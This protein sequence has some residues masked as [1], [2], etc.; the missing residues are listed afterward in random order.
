[1][2]A[3]LMGGNKDWAHQEIASRNLQ[4]AIAGAYA[5]SVRRSDTHS[6]EG[7]LDEFRR[8]VRSVQDKAMKRTVLLICIAVVDVSLAKALEVAK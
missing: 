3:L 5:S 1:M 8:S 2:H 4:C 7:N 6:Q